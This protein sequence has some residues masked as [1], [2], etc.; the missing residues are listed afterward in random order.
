MKCFLYWSVLVCLIGWS[1]SSIGQP[2]LRSTG[3]QAVNACYDRLQ[4]SFAYDD[5]DRYEAAQ[6]SVR[7][8]VRELLARDPHMEQ[9]FEALSDWL[10]VVTSPDHRLRIASWDEK[11]GGTRRDMAAMA[12]IRL[13]HGQLA[14]LRLDPPF[15]ADEAGT[16][17]RYESLFQ[18]STQQA[19]CY[20]VLGVGTYGGGHY[21]RSARLLEIK[22]DTLHDVPH[23]F[24]EVPLL[25]LRIPNQHEATLHFDPQTKTLT[26]PEFVADPESGWSR[27][28]GR[29][30][31]WQFEAGRFVSAL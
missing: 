24:G 31:H 8:A 11:S 6:D 28:T 30:V 12:Q 4:P 20:L 3:Y 16:D 17:V 22:D 14:Y 26:Y 27:P 18:L 10:S 1:L 19:N 2:D 5:F 15:T 25:E 21:H 29:E 7:Q 9:N 23:A 13:P